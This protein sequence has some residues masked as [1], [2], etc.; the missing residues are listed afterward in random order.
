MAPITWSEFY[1]LTEWLIRLIML[2][3]VPNR[4]SPAAARTWLLLIFLLPWPGLLLYAA[5]GRIYLP[6]KRIKQ[7]MLASQKIRAA[8]FQLGAVSA[9][10]GGLAVSPQAERAAALADNL[11]DFKPLGGNDVQLLT[12][13]NV[14]IELLIADIGAAKFHVHMLYYI[15]GADETG[16]RVADALIAAAKRG[17]NCRVLMD[18]VG[19]ARALRKLA[20][21]LRQ[22]GVE[23]NA[24]LPVGLFRRNAGRIDLRNHRKIAVIDGRIGYTG[25]QNIVDPCF[26]PGC[27]NEE[28]VARVAGPVVAHLQAIFFADRAIETDQMLDEPELFPD[29]PSPPTPPA[30]SAVAQLLPSGPGYG[31]ENAQA[32]MVDLIHSAMKRVVVTTPYF[33]PDEPFLQALQTAVLRGVEVSLV[34]PVHSNQFVTNLAQQSYYDE[35]LESGVRI[36]LYRPHFLHAKHL[37]VDDDVALIG[38][39]NIDIRSFALNAEVSLMVY[40]AGVMQQLRAIHDRYFANSNLLTREVWDQRGVIARTSQNIARLADSLL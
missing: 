34:L 11:G 2:F 6:K 28:L 22:A 21:R 8:R 40:D 38:S 32:L 5:I 29:P 30:G 3:Y 25:S 17:V 24:T 20:P 23:V 18:A 36:Y 13:Y 14:S 19:S 33:V 9:A 15:F 7:Q 31:R 26:I 4:R 12:D 27:P 39:S 37:S 35:L 10:A 1:Y 16:A